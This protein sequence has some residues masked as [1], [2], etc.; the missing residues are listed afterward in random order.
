MQLKTPTDYLLGL[1]IM[2]FLPALCEESLFRGGL[3]NFL[4]RSTK[5]PWL[6]IIIVSILFSAVHFSFYGFLPRMFLG[7]ILGL[8]Y[9][10]TGSLWLSILAHFANNAFA[11]SQYYFSHSTSVK[12][13]AEENTPLSFVY[14]GLIA[15]P[16][17]IFLLALLKRVSPRYEDES[18]S[19][20]DIRNRAPWET[21]K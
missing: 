18:L 10:S 5:K 9:Y 16:F 2:A 4:T 14:I 1:V 6:A 13:A 8:I 20:D 12:Q 11:V 3:Q 7:I 21:N 19:I 15:L 17:M